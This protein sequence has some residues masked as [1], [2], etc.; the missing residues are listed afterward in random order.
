MNGDKLPQL[1]R[2]MNKMNGDYLIRLK[3]PNYSEY[4]VDVKGSLNARNEEHRKKVSILLK[5]R[6][7]FL[8][9]LS[10]SQDAVYATLLRV[11]KQKKLL[12]RQKYKRMQEEAGQKISQDMAKAKP[13]PPINRSVY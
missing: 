5:D 12:Q 3:R 4:S 2:K 8:H 10:R 11:H 13:L 7:S 6:N 1:K 9:K